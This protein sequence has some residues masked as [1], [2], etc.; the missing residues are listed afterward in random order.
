MNEFS[1]PVSIVEVS[2]YPLQNDTETQVL[3]TV[4]CW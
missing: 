4:Y 2:A 1:H 3:V